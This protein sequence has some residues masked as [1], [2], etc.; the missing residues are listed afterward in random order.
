MPYGIRLAFRAIGFADTRFGRRC[1]QRRYMGRSLCH[2]AYGV[3][4]ALSALPIRALAALRGARP[5]PSPETQNFAPLL[6][7]YGVC[8]AL[9]Y[10]LI[11]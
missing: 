7:Q 4:F 3:R 9:P 1:T 5:S 10:K 11:L 2:T 8:F 6:G